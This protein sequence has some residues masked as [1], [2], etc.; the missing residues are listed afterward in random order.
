MPRFHGFLHPHPHS[1]PAQV[2]ARCLL[3]E[4]F[5]GCLFCQLRDDLVDFLVHLEK[6]REKL[7]VDR[8]GAMRNLG[9]HIQERKARSFKGAAGMPFRHRTLEFFPAKAL[10][11]HLE[12]K[13]LPH[14]VPAS[15]RRYSFLLFLVHAMLL[16]QRIP[17]ALACRNATNVPFRKGDGRP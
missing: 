4:I 15:L 1:A 16:L 12:E 10:K 9:F 7:G 6:E 5:R 17:I 8:G 13:S 3:Q 11:T 14:M 2:D